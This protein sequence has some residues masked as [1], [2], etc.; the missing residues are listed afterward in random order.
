[1]NALEA[2]RMNFLVLG[3]AAFNYKTM[4]QI[5]LLLCLLLAAVYGVSLLGML[6]VSRAV[7]KA[8]AQLELLNT[9]KEKGSKALATIGKQPAEESSALDLAS[10]LG[11]R[12]IWSPVLRRLTLQLPPKVW[13]TTLQATKTTGSDGRVVI[14]GFTKSQR[15]LT[16]F[17]MK[18]EAEG[19]FR[20]TE[21]SGMKKIEGEER[22]SLYEMTTIPV[23][24]KF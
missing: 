13:L 12:P 9:E 19:Y 5:F 3:R 24:E 15:E 17:M 7:V 8:K 4:V 21:L 14:T 11:S 1:M 10:I 23:M 16:N 18:L 2:S 6:Q 22:A 20:R